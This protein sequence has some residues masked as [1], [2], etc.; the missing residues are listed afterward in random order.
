MGQPDPSEMCGMQP[1]PR[2]GG[3]GTELGKLS[4]WERRREPGVGAVELA[5][6]AGILGGGSD[7]QRFDRGLWDYLWQNHFNIAAFGH[8]YEDAVCGVLSARGGNVQALNSFDGDRCQQETI[9]DLDPGRVDQFRTHNS[10]FP[11]VRVL[12]QEARALENE[13]GPGAEGSR[14]RK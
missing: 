3:T 2:T 12:Q 1:K 7:E 14:G 6:D 4:V 5:P 13:V 9:R 11:A 8:V 10:S